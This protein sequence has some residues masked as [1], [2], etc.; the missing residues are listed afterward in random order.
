MG[1]SAFDIGGAQWCRSELARQI[2]VM[3]PVKHEA[4]WWEWCRRWVGVGGSRWRDSSVDIGGSCWLS[5]S[6]VFGLVADGLVWVTF[7]FFFFFF[8]VCGLWVLWSK[9]G[10]DGGHWLGRRRWL[11]CWLGGEK[12]MWGL[13]VYTDCRGWFGLV[14][15]LM[16]QKLERYCHIWLACSFDGFAF[17]WL[18][19]VV[20][21]GPEVC[22]D[23]RIDVG[24]PHYFNGTNKQQ[25]RTKDKP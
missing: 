14:Q 18:S 9:A 21:Y 6:S 12:L 5:N 22:S 16:G 15:D 2:A 19:T 20:L 24:Q 3:E 10:I 4:V 25:N 17:K 1:S 11:F 13:G 23:T 7:F 8:L